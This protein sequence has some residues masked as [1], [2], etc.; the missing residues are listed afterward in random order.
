[1]RAQRFVAKAKYLGEWQEICEAIIRDLTRVNGTLYLLDIVRLLQ[2]GGSSAE[3][4]VAAF[5]QDFLERGK[6][7]LIGEVTTTELESIRKRLPGFVENFQLVTIKELPKP[8]IQSV[9]RQF[10]DY[11]EQQ[12]SIKVSEEALS[13]IYRLLYRYSPYEKFP[14]KGIKFLAKAISEARLN[15]SRRITRRD[16]LNQFIESGDEVGALVL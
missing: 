14:G 1:M 8:K 11:V 2:I 10:A 16:I 5:L 3:V 13:E 6:L 12:M 4:S 15:A 7:T 9:F